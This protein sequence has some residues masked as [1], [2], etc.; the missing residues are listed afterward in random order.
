MPGSFTNA[1]EALLLNHLFGG[2]P[3]QVPPVLYCAYMVGTPSES[4]PGSEPGLNSGYARVP[5][6]NNITNFPVT[7][8]QLKTLNID[9]LF[10]EALSNHGLVQA[11]GVFDSPAVGQGTMLAYSMLPNPVMIEVGDSY[12]IPAA[13]LTIAFQPGGL[14]NY[15]KNG[16][17]NML[18]GGNSFNLPTT[19]YFG[20][21]TTSP[22]DANP[23]TEP[24]I[25]GYVRVGL[26]NTV[27]LFPHSSEGIKTNALEVAYPEATAAQ[28]SIAAI[29]LFDQ[30]S[31]GNYLHRWE[32]PNPVPVIQGTQPVLSPSTLNVALN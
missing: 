1:G 23:G 3:L 20:Y 11:I 12:R 14:S 19:V 29:C 7:T 5:M 9:T 18:F 28:G 31:G 22:T 2:E 16:L 21:V 26:P 10:P 27:Q 15:S 8:N 17:L 4:G 30:L 32:L 24:A 25:G 13:S 6:S